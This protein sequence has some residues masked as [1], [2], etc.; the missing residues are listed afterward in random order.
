LPNVVLEA[1]AMEVP[2][3]ATQ[4]AGVADLIHDG[5]QGRVFQ[6]GDVRGIA[7][8]A[9]TM[10]LDRAGTARMVESAR[11]RVCRHFSFRERVRKLE[12]VYIE[13]MQDVTH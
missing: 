11:A 5:E 4:V 10:L 3:I 13:M 12:N 9:V 8:A 7:A 1:M 2:V 6:P